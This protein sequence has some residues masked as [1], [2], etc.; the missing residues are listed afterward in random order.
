MRLPPCGLALLLVLVTSVPLAAQTVG[1]TVQGFITDSANNHA[2]PGVLV[3]IGGKQGVTRSDGKYSI[4]GVPAGTA[5]LK[6]R[7]IGYSPVTRQVTVADGEI[8]TVDIALSAQAIDLSEMVVIGYG[9]QRAADITGAVSNVTS[10]EFNPGRVVTPTELIQNKVAGVQV[11][12]NNEPGGGTTIRIRG[13]TSINAS[14]EPLYVVDGVPLGTGAG[15]GISAGRDPLNF[16]NSSDIES[17]TVLRDASAAS[18][19]GA[20]AANGVVLITTKRGRGGPPRFEYSSSYSVSKVTRVPDMLNAAQFRQAV[21]DHAPGNVAQL[22]DANTNWFDEITQSGFGQEQNFAMSGSTASSNYRFS[23]NYLDQEGVV[24]GTNTERVSLGINYDQRLINDALSLKFNVRGSRALDK[25]TPGG[26]LSNAAQM[27]PTQPVFDSAAATGYFDWGVNIQSADNPVA[28]AHLAKNQAT[29]LRSVG[30]M[31]A[32]Y[33]IPK[34]AGLS[35]NLNL[36]YDVT[37]AER[38]NF[39]PSTLHGQLRNGNYGNY[40]RQNPSQTNTVFETFANYAVPKEVGPGLLDLTGGYS[41][42]KSH[43]EYPSTSADSLAT[44]LLGVNGIPAAKTVKSTQFINDSRLIS[45]FARA[46]YNIDSRYLFN[47]SLR[48]DGSSRFGPDNQWGTFPSLAAAWRLSEEPFL[49]DKLNLSDLKLRASWAK[50]GNQSFGDY[51]WSSTYTVSNAQA[52]YYMGSDGFVSTIRPSAVDPNIKWE[53]TRSVDLGIDFGFANQR[54]SGAIDWYDKKTT[55]LIFSVPAAAGTVPG[56]FVTTNIGSMRNRGIEF[57]LS[58]RVLENRGNP[59]GLTW[60]ADFTAARNHNELL[61]ITPFGGVG[62]QILTGGIS[63]GVGQTIQVLRPGQE[64]NSFFVY[65]QKYAGGKPVNGTALEMY[66]DLNEDGQINQDDL[67]PYHSPTPKWILGHSSYLTYNKF[68]LGVTLRA[69]LGNYV[70]NN[71]AAVLGTYSEVN[72]ASPFNLH[73]SV[74]ETGFQTQQ[75]FSDYYVEKASFL[76]MDNLTLGYS[77]NVRGQP[78]RVYG[79]IQNV[80]TITGYSGVDPAAGLNGIDNNLYPRSRTF[81]GGLSLQF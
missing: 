29:T 27:G 63:G 58:A 3:T 7:T 25:F 23:A 40:N 59:R 43:A 53:A 18:I 52:Q 11:V 77:L 62:Q 70:Y 55:D 61:T 1:G 64:V 78:A 47:V 46:N 4:V 14:S 24:F 36:G 49:K 80:F 15:G 12:E 39:E 76:R 30:N 72:R 41:F 2:L 10:D 9:E 74:L 38:V 48:R 17:I 5:D 73:K 79:T 69:Y 42:S 13:S 50:T 37:R 75:L 26:V 51:L 8:V 81:T 67:R 21:T 66:E 31:Q 16:L 32:A 54:I 6:V 68:D 57:S 19:Y 44:D 22:Q 56:D 65:K 35:A 34:L 20:N 60:Q 28:L 71:V 33:N 45:F